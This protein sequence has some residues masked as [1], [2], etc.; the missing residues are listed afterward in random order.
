MPTRS[1]SRKSSRR[2]SR[3]ISRRPGEKVCTAYKYKDYPDRYTKQEI[4]D[5]TR[6]K[7]GIKT[8]VSR[9]KPLKELCNAL[10]IDYIKKEPKVKKTVRISKKPSYIP[11]SPERVSSRCINKSQL[12]LKEHQKKVVKYLRNHRG[13]IAVHQVGSGKTLTAVTASQC[14]LADHPRGR[15]IVLTPTSLQQNFKKEVRAYGADP[16]DPRYEFHTL[17]GFLLAS[18]KGEVNCKGAFLIIDE[19][20]NLRNPPKVGR[21]GKKEGITAEAVIECAKKAYKVL[22]LTATPVVNRPSDIITLKAI[23][24]GESPMTEKR[25]E[26]IVEDPAL[27]KKEFKCVFSFY[28]TRS[29]EVMD[30]YPEA[31]THVVPMRMTSKFLRAYEEIERAEEDA[32]Q[33]MFG[34]ANVKVFYN[35]VRRAVNSIEQEY[36]PKVDFVVKKISEKLKKNPANKA[37]VFSHFLEAGMKLVI[38]RLNKAKISYIH[39]DGS[40]S[41]KKRKEAVDRYNANKVTVLLISKAGGEGLDLKGTRQIFILE[42]AWNETSMEQVIGR[43]VR[44]RSHIHLPKKEQKVDIYRILMV[45]PEEADNWEKLSKMSLKEVENSVIGR[46]GVDLYLYKLSELKDKLNN[47]FL[48]DLQKISIEKSKC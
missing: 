13:V 2:I 1:R 30:E 17:Q 32:A 26:E 25:F 5:L 20:H 47:M 36:S 12:P 46:V 37:V 28:T 11:R 3:R 15:V 38:K 45:K 48:K 14:Y 22:L 23:V 18:R 10:N 27:F 34:D 19:A 9:K 7:L 41:Q 35:G 4:I 40:M 24:D 44:Y 42:P 16:E 6:A 29:Q 8:T 31:R 33:A 43:G 21:G 39:I